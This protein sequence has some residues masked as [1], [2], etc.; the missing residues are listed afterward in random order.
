MERVIAG[1]SSLSFLKTDLMPLSL[2]D[3]FL[4]DVLAKG[5]EK[6]SR[7]SDILS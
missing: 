5:I 3:V 2:P 6:L 7:Y 1:S 4:I